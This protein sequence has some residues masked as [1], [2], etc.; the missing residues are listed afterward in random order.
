MMSKKHERTFEIMCEVY[1]S[2][3]YE[4][5]FELLNA[6]HWSVAQNRERV[7]MIGKLKQ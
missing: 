4:I 7:F 3:G 1:S 5:D 2:L 6:K